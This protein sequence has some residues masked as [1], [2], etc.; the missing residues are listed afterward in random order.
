MAKRSFELER[1]VRIFAQED[2][3]NHWHNLLSDSDKFMEKGAKIMFQELK[4]LGEVRKLIDIIDKK[5]QSASNG[6]NKS[7]SRGHL[8][9]QVDLGLKKIHI[10]D[11]AGRESTDTTQSAK[12]QK[13]T[14]KINSSLTTLTQKFQLY[15]EGR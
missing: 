15:R 1:V 3:D 11:L 2:Y 13:E 14:K 8:L 9:L 4:T 7:S 6:V 5:R 10:I 12:I